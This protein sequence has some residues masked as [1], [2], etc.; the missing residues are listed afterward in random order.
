MS[1]VCSGRRSLIHCTTKEALFT[2]FLHQVNETLS[3]KVQANAEASSDTK[4]HWL[5]NM[6]PW[7]LAVLSKR[8]RADIQDEERQGFKGKWSGVIGSKTRS[9]TWSPV[10]WHLWADGVVPHDN[11]LVVDSWVRL[12][13]YHLTTQ[14]SMSLHWDTGTS[15]SGWPWAQWCEWH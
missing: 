7:I 13:V 1:L 15:L 9:F 5:W 12:L 2:S 10:R 8:Q 3:E 4:A 14:R 11:V 6:C